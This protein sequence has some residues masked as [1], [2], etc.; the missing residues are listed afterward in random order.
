MV[1]SLT[2]FMLCHPKVTF[3]TG[4]TQ[5]PI[6]GKAKASTQTK[7]IPNSLFP[8]FPLV[9]DSLCVSLCQ[10]FPSPVVVSSS[11]TFHPGSPLHTG[12]RAPGKYFWIS[13]PWVPAS[14]HKELFHSFSLAG[15]PTSVL[16]G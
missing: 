2:V 10:I 9:I 7:G 5:W 15:K 1:A 14:F 16:P 13:S 6:R 12:W 3:P 11:I 4:T 8:H